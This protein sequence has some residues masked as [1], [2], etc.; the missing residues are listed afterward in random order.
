MHEVHK[1]IIPLLER[2]D[3]PTAFFAGND[4]LCFGIYSAAHTCS[5][6]IPEDISIVGYDDIPTSSLMQ[7]PLTTFW[8]P[9]QELAKAS[10]DYLINQ[11]QH[12]TIEPPPRL[13]G[14]II[15]RKSV[16]KI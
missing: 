3:H 2:P 13:R 1:L 4:M 15:E 5:M 12:K 11:I 10:V 9:E 7:P 8:Q 14:K 6:R 16:A